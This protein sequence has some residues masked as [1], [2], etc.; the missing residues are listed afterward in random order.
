MKQS[1]PQELKTHK[2]HKQQLTALRTRYELNT[3]RVAL[4]AL[5]G[6]L[7]LKQQLIADTDS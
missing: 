3:S 4:Y 7:T 5:R 2:S 1:D 6:V